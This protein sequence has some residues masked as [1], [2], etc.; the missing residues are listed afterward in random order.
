MALQRPVSN[1]PHSRLYGGFNSVRFDSTNGL[2][3]TA[4]NTDLEPIG[5]RVIRYGCLHRRT[6]PSMA[7]TNRWLLN[8]PLFNCTKHCVHCNREMI[9][10]QRLSGLVK[11]KNTCTPY[12]GQ[13]HRL[14]QTRLTPQEKICASCSKS[15]LPRRNDAVTCS[16]R[17]RQRV[18]RQRTSGAPIGDRYPNNFKGVAIDANDPP[19]FESQAV[20]LKRYGLLLAGEDRRLKTADR[21]PEVI[22]RME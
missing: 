20:Y 19:T 5:S 6:V 3:V 9:F 10:G 7:R 22:S 11:I 12:C 8:E 1:G 2:S 4:S 21:A 16:D 15:F 18:H 14:R 13:Q 17:C